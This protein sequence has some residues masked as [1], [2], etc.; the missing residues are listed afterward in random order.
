MMQAKSIVLVVAL[1]A[2]FFAGTVAIQQ[3]QNDVDTL[4]VVYAYG[5]RL[6]PPYQFT[7]AGGDTL[8]LNG[9][10]FVPQRS[11]VSPSLARELSK[12]PEPQR[13]ELLKRSHEDW[14]FEKQAYDSVKT[15]YDSGVP[16]EDCLEAYAEIFRTH[17]HVKSVSIVSHGISLIYDNG[18]CAQ[19]EL[20]FD[21]IA[22]I[23]RRAQQQ[24]VMDRF[25]RTIT[26]GGMVAFGATE[27]GSY[28]LHTPHSQLQKTF[29]QFAKLEKGEELSTA[30]VRDTPLSNA[31]FRAEMTRVLKACRIREE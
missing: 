22:P 21:A 12:I 8:Y 7:G 3:S 9:H 31:E 25:W 5:V 24:S 29:E 18:D 27:V 2:V 28:E 19:A 10:P 23:D 4:G 17:P 13:S 14:L 26:A 11:P 16:Y 6:S 1:M 15:M 20:S 30:D